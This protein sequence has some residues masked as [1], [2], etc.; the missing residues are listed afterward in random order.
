MDPTKIYTPSFKLPSGGQ[1]RLHTAKNIDKAHALKTISGTIKFELE[2]RRAE[3]SLYEFVKQA[4]HVVE[5]GVEFSEGW[6]IHTI[7]DHL[8]AVSERRIKNLIINIPPR[9]S[10]STICSVIWPVWAWLKHPQEKFLTASYSGSLSVRD[11]VKSRRL[12]ESTWFQ[13]RWSHIS[14]NRDQNTKQRYENNDTGYRIAA[15]VGGTTTGE[16]GSTLLI[17]DAHGAQDAQ[18]D[19][20]RGSTLEWLDMV[21]SSRKNDPRTSC[22]VVIMQRLHAMDATGH[23]LKQGGYEHL[24]LPAEYDGVKRRTSLGEYDPRTEVGE[25]LWP[26]RFGKTELDTLKKALGA[27]GASGQLQQNPVPSGGGILKIDH[28]QLWPYTVELPDFQYI[29]ISLDTAFTEKTSGDPTGCIVFGVFTHRKQQCVMV[30]DAWT[31]HLSYPDLKE[32]VMD[33]WRSSYGAVE[34]NQLKKGRR[35][36]TL[37]IEA[38]ASGQSLLQDMRL[39]NIPAISYNPGK[40]DKVQRAHMT[41][42]ILESDCVYVMESKKRPGEPISWAKP[43][44]KEWETFP[45][46]EHDEYVDCLTQTI[47]YLKDSGWLE[48]PVHEDDE[49]DRYTDDDRS[50]SNPYAQ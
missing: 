43:M 42:P 30:L 7:C 37:L 21:W 12:L 34:G 22:S 46:A 8:E 6:H 18:S 24:C 5:P 17:D 25:L 48:V 31:D 15:S 38:K 23:L 50:R 35:A 45:V 47:I 41:A 49:P 39:S 19:T 3:A 20:M 29:V 40:A 9:H 33:D 13:E 4:W 26:N 2:K 28:V 16:G 11:A 32:H 27:Y 1:R 36:D 14:L 10:K 44:L